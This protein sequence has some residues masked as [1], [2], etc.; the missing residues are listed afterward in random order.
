[1]ASLAEMR[2]LS[3]PQ[4][5]AVRPAVQKHEGSTPGRGPLGLHDVRGE[6]TARGHAVEGLAGLV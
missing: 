2:D 4:A 3:V 6:D 5:R 1:M